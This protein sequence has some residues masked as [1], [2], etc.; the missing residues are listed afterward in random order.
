MTLI[1][2][3]QTLKRGAP[4]PPLPKT[5]RPSHTAPGGAKNTLHN[6]KFSLDRRNAHGF[7]RK[8]DDK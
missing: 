1:P 7:R 6:V 2:K 5:D 8:M 4:P 3:M